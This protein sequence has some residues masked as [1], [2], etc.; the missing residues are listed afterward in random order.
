MGRVKD[1]RT[2]ALPLCVSAH[3]KRSVK[4]ETRVLSTATPVMSVVSVT[5]P[6]SIDRPTRSA[7]SPVIDAAIVLGTSQVE[8]A[9]MPHKETGVENSPAYSITICGLLGGAALLVMVNAH[10]PPPPSAALAQAPRVVAASHVPPL[11]HVPTS[12]ESSSIQPRIG[13]LEV[14]APPAASLAVW[15]IYMWCT[16]E[17][18][19][20]MVVPGTTSMASSSW[21]KSS[22]VLVSI[23]P[24]AP[25]WSE[26]ILS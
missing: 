12:V 9:T 4:S 17:L 25:S 20:F 24:D 14:R 10:E 23:R 1:M 21:K 18:D 15:Y 2:R 26:S 8:S 22:A 16:S 19:T 13:S 7:R 3:G 6:T 11:P 5:T